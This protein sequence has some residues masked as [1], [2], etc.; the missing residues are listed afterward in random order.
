MYEPKC[1]SNL[2]NKILK[3]DSEFHSLE[4]LKAIH[5]RDRDAEV[6]RIAAVEDLAIALHASMSNGGIPSP[7]D[8]HYGLRVMAQVVGEGGLEDYGPFGKDVVAPLAQKFNKRLSREQEA[9]QVNHLVVRVA[10]ETEPAY[11]TVHLFGD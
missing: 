11:K 7:N 1:Y 8:F 6:A 2:H 10:G 4:Q 3:V 9:H 5:S